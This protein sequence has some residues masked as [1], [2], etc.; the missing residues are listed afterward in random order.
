MKLP[1]GVVCHTMGLARNEGR[2]AVEGSSE[3]QVLSNYD[4][5]KMLQSLLAEMVA[6][7]EETDTWGDRNPAL[8]QVPT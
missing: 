7:V 3:R 2:A 1:K 8:A 6:V 5:E 4:V